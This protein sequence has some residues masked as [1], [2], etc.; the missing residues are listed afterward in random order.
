[1]ENLLVIFT[2]IV[3][4]PAGLVQLTDEGRKSLKDWSAIC[5]L[6]RKIRWSLFR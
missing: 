6:P 4:P 2:Q 3:Y 1:M 5:I